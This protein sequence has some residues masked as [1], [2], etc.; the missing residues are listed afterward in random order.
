MSR[1]VLTDDQ[2]KLAEDNIKLVYFYADRFVGTVPI[3][4]D[5][6]QAI[7]MFA[8]CKAAGTYNSSINIKFSTYAT[9]CMHNEL[10][11]SLRQ[12]YKWDKVAYLEDT[13]SNSSN[14]VDKSSMSPVDAIDDKQCDRLEDIATTHVIVEQLKEW[15]VKQHK[16]MRPTTVKVLDT[17]VN[18]P[19]ITQVAISK[20]TG[21]SQTQVSQI[22]CKAKERIIDTFFMGDKNFLIDGDHKVNKLSVDFMACSKEVDKKFRKKWSCR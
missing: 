6:I 15:L 4:R 1:L 18:N 9:V 12:E 20:K 2:R 13:L 22:L 19:S 3:D 14:V 7:M 8:F 17:W 5:E 10:R 16:Y 11:M 21:V